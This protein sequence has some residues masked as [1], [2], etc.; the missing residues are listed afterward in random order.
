VLEDV[1][2]P[3]GHVVQVFGSLLWDGERVLVRGGRSGSSWLREIVRIRDGVGGL[4]VDVFR[5]V[6]RER[7]GDGADSFFWTN[8]WLEGIPFC[9][10]FCRLFDLI[11]NKSSTVADM[12]SLGWGV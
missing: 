3:R 5:R 11:E 10:R 6:C 2:G 12:C 7:W 1:S 4:G 8:P 9:V